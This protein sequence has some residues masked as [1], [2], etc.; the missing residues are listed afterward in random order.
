MSI[1]KLT[2]ADCSCADLHFLDVGEAR[3][4]L[5]DLIAARQSLQS[6]RAARVTAA[7]FS[8]TATRQD[9]LARIDRAIAECEREEC[10]LQQLIADCALSDLF[11]AV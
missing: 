11:D 5:T 3:D 8:P 7:E 10:Q 2:A 4:Y 6:L 9:D 1:H